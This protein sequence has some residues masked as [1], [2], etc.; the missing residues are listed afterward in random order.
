MPDK[1]DKYRRYPT[2]VNNAAIDMTSGASVSH[3]AAV[4]GALEA[5]PFTGD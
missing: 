4:S 1:A 5:S 3:R 2:W